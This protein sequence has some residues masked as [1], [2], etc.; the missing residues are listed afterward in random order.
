MLNTGQTWEKWG[1]KYKGAPDRDQ[2]TKAQSWGKGC[3]AGLP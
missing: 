1:P 3:D 2:R